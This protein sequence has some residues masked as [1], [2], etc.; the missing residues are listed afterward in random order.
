MARDEA[1][2]RVRLDTSAARGDLRALTRTAANVAGR[3]GQG[4]RRSVG[5]GLGAVGLGGGVG[6]GLAAVRGATQSGLGDVIGEAFGGIGARLAQTLFG[7]LD[8]TAKADKRAREETIQAFGTIAGAT[9]KIPEGAVNWFNSV[10][11]LRLQEEKGRELFEQD[12]N[13]RSTSAGDLVDRVM[14]GLGV[15]I[16]EAVDALAKKLNPLNWFR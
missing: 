5:R 1:K 6:A 15:L 9:G 14:S 8:E 10:Q 16:S 3:V 2:V 7:D 4:L 13:F 11:S 12:D